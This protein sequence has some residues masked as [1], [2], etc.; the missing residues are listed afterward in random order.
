MALK[1]LSDF[2]T[3]SDEDVVYL[4][5]MKKLIENK[6]CFDSFKVGEKILVCTETEIYTN[7]S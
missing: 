4:V 5:L 6:V 2:L 7:C 3:E 1:I